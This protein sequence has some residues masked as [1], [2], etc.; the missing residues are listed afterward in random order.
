MRPLCSI[1]LLSLLHLHSQLYTNSKSKAILDMLAT[2]LV[3]LLFSTLV[4][5]GDSEGCL[6]SLDS[7]FAQKGVTDQ[8][9]FDT[10]GGACKGTRAIK[11]R[12]TRVSAREEWILH[13]CC[14]KK[15]GEFGPS[16]MLPLQNCLAFN[17][18]GGGTLTWQK[19][20][21]Y[22]LAEACKDCKVVG[23][24][25]N[26]TPGAHLRCSCEAPQQTAK[27]Y[28]LPIHADLWTEGDVRGERM[29]RYPCGVGSGALDC[30][31]ARC[32]R[33]PSEHIDPTGH[34]HGQGSPDANDADGPIRGRDV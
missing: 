15:N 19:T 32:V 5:A 21:S 26:G 30:G 22:R 23:A 18:A 12:L 33:N 31:W 8:P 6:H 9:G 10:F 25:Q 13:S 16:R 3:T 7:F 4:L 17:D 34:W 29:S 28:E 14:Q 2:S 1:P 11:D 20:T 27:T 24:S